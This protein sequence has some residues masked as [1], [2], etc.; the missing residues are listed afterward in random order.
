MD[1]KLGPEPDLSVSYFWYEP[2]GEDT[3]K[4]N[5]R[6]L[7]HLHTDGTVFLS[8]TMLGEHFVIRLAI[9]SFRTKLETIDL[10]VDML[11][12]CLQLTKKEFGIN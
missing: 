10:A 3:N 6:L 4:F 5:K 2:E 9:G 8:S 7:E 11:K 1:F 12:S